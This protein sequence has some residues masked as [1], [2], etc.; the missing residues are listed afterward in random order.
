[1]QTCCHWNCQKDVEF[2]IDTVRTLHDG[3]VQFAGP[4]P[5]SDYSYACVDHVGAMLGWQIDAP[6]TEEI[7]WTIRRFDPK[8]PG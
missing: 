2:Q 6:K 4:D 1:M 7:Y 8:K 3:K 5:L